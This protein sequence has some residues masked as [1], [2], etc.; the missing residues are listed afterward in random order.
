MKHATLTALA[1]LVIA[2]GVLVP[3]LCVGQ[4]SA[5]SPMQHG[6]MDQTMA[7]MPMR[8]SATDHKA[9]GDHGSMD[10]TAPMEHDHE[11]VLRDAAEAAAEDGKEVG[12]EERLGATLSD[13]QFL[14][15]DGKPV[16]LREL[17]SVPTILLPI[18][19]KCP[20]VCNLLQSNFAQILPEVKLTPGKEIQ[21]VSLSF[22]PRDTPKD[23]AN[24][25]RQYVA[26][27]QGGFPA[28]HWRFLTGDQAAIDSALDSI[29]YTVRRQ[30]GLYAHPV[31]IVAIAPGGKI[32]RYLYGPGFLPMDV[33]IAATKAAQ[34]IE[35][36]SVKRLLS[37]CYSYDPEGRRYVFSTLRVAG[38]SIMLFVAAF[39]A[40]LALGGKKKQKGGKR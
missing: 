37:M 12:I 16:H 5:V 13:A 40:F 31:S 33:T 7:D 22:D 8:E 4:D 20:D 21:V 36:L 11:Q 17:M 26:A 10:M 34:G 6:D 24:A 9:N 35:S 19:F 14:D 2:T 28:E 29:G 25:K 30:G 15:A 38:F 39:V 32:V 27:L 23:A 1:V 3:A 18:Y